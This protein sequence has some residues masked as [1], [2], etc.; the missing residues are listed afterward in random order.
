MQPR[1]TTGPY[2]ELSG[3]VWGSHL[4][5]EGTKKAYEQFNISG[6]PISLS[7]DNGPNWRTKDPM[8]QD[9]MSAGSPA[10]H[11]FGV[12]WT[13][14]GVSLMASVEVLLTEHLFTDCSASY[15]IPLELLKNMKQHNETLFFEF[16]FD[17][18]KI[19]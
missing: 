7:R 4:Y 2:E 8:N 14:D 9:K 11:R 3:A 10:H 1:G 19:L 18:F 13:G 15:R 5:Y 17:L 16:A 6:R 12:H